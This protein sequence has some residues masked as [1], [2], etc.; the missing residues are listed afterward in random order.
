MPQTVGINRIN[1]K[2]WTL[3]FPTREVQV[4][5]LPTQCESPDPETKVNAGNHN[6]NWELFTAKCPYKHYRAK[7]RLVLSPLNAYFKTES[8][9][10]VGE[11]SVQLGKL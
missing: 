2:D 8:S 7:H 5:I 10:E 6:G 3:L 11:A 4:V 1:P 9:V